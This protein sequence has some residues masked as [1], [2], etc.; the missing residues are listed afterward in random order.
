MMVLDRIF[1]FIVVGLKRCF[2]Q[3]CVD[4]DVFIDIF[5]SLDDVKIYEIGICD[6]EEVEIFLF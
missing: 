3:V 6:I 5:Q 4:V 1:R 2:V